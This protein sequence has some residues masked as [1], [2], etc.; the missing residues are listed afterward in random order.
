MP[1]LVGGMSDGNASQME[2]DIA[3][4]IGIGFDTKRRAARDVLGIGLGWG[5][6]SNRSFNEQITTEMFYRFQL[7]QN[8]AFTLSTQ[9]I[10]DPVAG[11]TG[12]EIWVFGFKWRMTF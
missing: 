2:A 12:D 10:K 9:Y 7:L 1:F 11:E 6:P 5:K 3:G 4:G 8:I